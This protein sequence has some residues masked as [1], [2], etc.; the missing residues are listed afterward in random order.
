MPKLHLRKEI[1]ALDGGRDAQL[2]LD[3]ERGPQEYLAVGVRRK[4]ACGYR[5]LL[6]FLSAQAAQAKMVGPATLH[7]TESK[8]GSTTS[9]SSRRAPTTGRGQTRTEEAAG[10]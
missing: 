5:R 10:S 2:L 4:R 8:P 3:D 9:E 7:S 6:A 1:P